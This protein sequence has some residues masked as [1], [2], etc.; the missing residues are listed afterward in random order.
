MLVGC[1]DDYI[2]CANACKLSGLQ[3]KECTVSDSLYRDKSCK[4]GE[5]I[6]TEV[7]KQ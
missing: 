2:V 4:C 1:S 5:P 7:I 3:M 6:R